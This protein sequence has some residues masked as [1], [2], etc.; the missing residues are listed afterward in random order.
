MMSR[1]LVLLLALDHLALVLVTFGNCRPGEYISSAAWSMKLAGKRRGA[2]AVA[3]IDFLCQWIE[4]DHCA[5]SWLG[6][7]HLYGEVRA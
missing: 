7:K 1:G 5:H 3:V 2:L 6:Q 4:K